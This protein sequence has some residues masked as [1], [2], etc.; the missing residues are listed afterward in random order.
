MKRKHCF[1]SFIVVVL[2]LLF[3]G[4]L[5]LSAQGIIN[6]QNYTDISNINFKENTEARIEL[7]SKIFA[8]LYEAFKFKPQYIYERETGTT[9][10]FETVK[11]ENALYMLILNKR[12]SSFP[13]LGQGNYIVKRSLKDG[14]FIQV[15]IFIRNDPDSF[16][17]IY[18]FRDRS[19]FDLTLYGFPLFREVVL[20][21]NFNSVLT[22]PFSEIMELSQNTVDWS[23]VLYRGSRRDSENLIDIVKKIRK[24][25]Y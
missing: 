21:I 18:P 24:A 14:H 10:K 5:N 12:G 7:N 6:P 17:R 16:I 20:P 25:K 2:I 13:I 8:P 4:E 3:S 19:Y 11:S 9:V 15:K 23:L 1:Y 22:S